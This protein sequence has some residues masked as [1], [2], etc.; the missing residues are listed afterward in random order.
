MVSAIYKK[1]GLKINAVWFCNDINKTINMS[2]ADFVFLHGVDTNSYKTAIT[3]KQFSL[4]TDLKIH[5]EEIFKGFSK[6]YRY[7]INRAKKENVECVTY[8][9]VDLKNNTNLLRSF[10]QEYDEFVKLKGIENT[11]NDLGMEQY[12]QSGNVI[13]TKAFKDNVDYAQ[14]VYV[15]DKETARLLYSVSNFRT[16]GVDS[17]LIGRA[18]KYLHWYDIQ[19]LHDCKVNILDWGGISSIDNPN[20]V[21]KFKREFG[22]HECSYYNVIIGKSI[23]GKIAV[24]L[25]KLKRG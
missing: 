4:T 7:E 16:E 14:H 10:K 11:Y 20:G 15:C 21:D 1:K 2:K 19:Y 12:I 17:N 25:M 5:P 23:I 3:S 8:N 22:G 6:N 24:S 9:S 13:L 18:N